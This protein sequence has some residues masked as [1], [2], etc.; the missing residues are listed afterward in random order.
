MKNNKLEW[1]K[2]IIAIVVVIS[3][4]FL[5]EMNVVSNIVALVITS[6]VFIVFYYQWILKLIKWIQKVIKK[7]IS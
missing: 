3:I 2:L 7:K 5:Y 4:R 6:S 1:I